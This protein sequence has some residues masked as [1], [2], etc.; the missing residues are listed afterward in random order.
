M[1]IKKEVNDSMPSSC[2]KFSQTKRN[3][4]NECAKGQTVVSAEVY[5]YK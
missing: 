4:D 1:H 5:Q 2:S 3:I